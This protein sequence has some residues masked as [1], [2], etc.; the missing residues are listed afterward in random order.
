MCF[1]W[2]TDIE[3]DDGLHND[4][5]YLLLC[6]YTKDVIEV[7]PFQSRV[8]GDCYNYTTVENHTSEHEE[9]VIDRVSN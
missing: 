5:Y 9:V 7:S 8:G 1:I 6:A 4:Y 2:N 3:V